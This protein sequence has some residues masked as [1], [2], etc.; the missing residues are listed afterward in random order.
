LIN[1]FTCL[2]LFYC[3]FYGIYLFPLKCFYLFTSVLWYFFKGTIYI[4]LKCLY[5]LPEMVF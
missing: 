5:H 1:Y 3:N 2:V 4:L